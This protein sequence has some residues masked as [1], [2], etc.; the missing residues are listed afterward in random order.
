MSFF[1]Y[2]ALR[3]LCIVSRLKIETLC[4]ID[5]FVM[6]LAQGRDSLKLIDYCNKLK[7]SYHNKPFCT[8]KQWDNKALGHGVSLH[9]KVRICNLSM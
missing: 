4:L 8:N 5:L 7:I 9:I 6:I 2:D 3:P 1:S